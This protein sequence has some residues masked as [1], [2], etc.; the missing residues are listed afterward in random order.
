[1]SF[2]EFEL[3]GEKSRRAPGIRYFEKFGK[4]AWEAFVKGMGKDKVFAFVF[5]FLC[6][7]KIFTYSKK[8]VVGFS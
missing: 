4:A 6:L 7:K 5:Q 3:N 8:I 2:H 1:M